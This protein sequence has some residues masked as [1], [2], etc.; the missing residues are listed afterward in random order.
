MK[1]IRRLFRLIQINFILARY[2][3]DQIIF[4]LHLFRPLRFFLYCNPWNWG[5]NRKLSRAMRLRLAIEA[6][7]PIFVKFGQALS[8]RRDLLPADVADELA[9]LQDNVPPFSGKLAISIIE[10]TCAKPITELFAEFNSVPL[11]SASIAQAHAA[12]LFGGQEVVVKVLR[13]NIQKLVNRDIDLLYVLAQ[14]AERYWADSARLHPYEIVAEFE[15]SLIDE[16]NLKR[17]AANASQLRRNFLHSPLLYI[18][19]VHWAYVHKNILVTERIFGIPVSDIAS[20]KR[21]NIDFKKLAERGVEIFFTQVLRDRFFHADMH[22]GNIFVSPEHPENPQYLGVDFGIIGTLSPADQRYIAENLL[23][24]FNRDYYRIAILH[25]ESG[26]VPPDTRI[27]IFESTIRTVCE[28]IFERPLKDI[29]FGQLLLS[30]FQAAQQF[31]ME[32]QPQ[33]LLLQKTLFNVEGLGRTLYPDLDLWRTAKPFLERWMKRELG[34][35][36]FMRKLRETAPYWMEKLP[37]FPDLI[38]QMLV[39]QRSQMRSEAFKKSAEKKYK[40][41]IKR[42]KQNIALSIILTAGTTAVIVHIF[43][44]RFF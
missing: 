16:L 44:L 40:K 18:P 32:I 42:L 15:R 6:L 26:W 41:R 24:F 29:S 5:A 20:L 19:E 35:R 37:E 2:G 28:P 43:T 10:K 4:S 14:L 8:T 17:E 34:P 25:V 7:G 3:L 30:L 39:E 11:A 12:K 22:P 38:Y 1:T 31:K 21:H 9:R 27:D 33:L 23:A 36:A 13:P